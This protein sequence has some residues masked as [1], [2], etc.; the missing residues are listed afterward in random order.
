[1][2]PQL[3]DDYDKEAPTKK[4]PGS[5]AKRQ[6]DDVSKSIPPAKKS[7]VAISDNDCEVLTVERPVAP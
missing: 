5:K 6:S 3:L 2:K 4:N 7:K 1:V